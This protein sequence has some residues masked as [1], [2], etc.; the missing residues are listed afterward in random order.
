M[1]I[2]SLLASTMSIGYRASQ[3]K[4]RSAFLIQEKREVLN[5][6]TTYF[7]D[8]GTY[9]SSSG[10]WACLGRVSTTCWMNTYNGQD[11][12]WGQ[13]S[14]YFNDQ[15]PI[16]KAI[17]NTLASDGYKYNSPITFNGIP[18]S[19]V[20]ILMKSTPFT[21]ADCPPPSYSENGLDPVYSYCWYI[22][23]H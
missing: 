19:S 11:Y 13:I 9:P 17:P 20:I 12:L 4:A 8:N 2:I 21:N 7:V 23:P 6:L 10:V 15:I 3:N 5:G 16:P 1:S 18:D 14:K 22:L